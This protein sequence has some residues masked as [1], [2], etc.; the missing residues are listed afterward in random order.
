MLQRLRCLRADKHAALMA[1]DAEI[2]PLRASARELDGTIQHMLRHPS[3]DGYGLL[4]DDDRVRLHRH[5]LDEIRAEIERLVALQREMARKLE[6]GRE[7]CR[8]S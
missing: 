5:P 1:I 2:A 4:P 3:Q 6:T 7:Y 8:P